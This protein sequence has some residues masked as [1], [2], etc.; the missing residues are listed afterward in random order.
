MYNVQLKSN[1]SYK[2]IISIKTVDFI[3]TVLATF[4]DRHTAS[5]IMMCITTM[6][7]QQQIRK[8]F[9]QYNN[10]KTTTR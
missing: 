9:T 7:Q 3:I 6:V 5:F 10:T 2:T 4:N 1:N 8:R